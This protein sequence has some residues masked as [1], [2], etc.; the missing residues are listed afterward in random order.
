MQERGAAED[1]NL[2]IKGENMYKLTLSNNKRVPCLWEKGGGYKDTGEATLITGKG[3]QQKKA[4]HIPTK[5]HL[6]CK[7]H[8]LIPISNGDYVIEA[9]QVKQEFAIQ[10]SQIGFVVGEKVKS[11]LIASYSAGE[12]DIEP[13]GQLLEA[14]EAA[15]KKAMD[16]HCR[17][18]YWIK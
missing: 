8:A 4:I 16:Y 12:W 7:E 9:F 14:V 10:I 13:A 11:K 3:G 2:T 18:P 5:G 6:A 17:R 15:K 1:A